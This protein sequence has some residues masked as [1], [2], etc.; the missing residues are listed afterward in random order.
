[1]GACLLPPHHPPPAAAL[2]PEPA[3]LSCHRCHCCHCRPAP[4]AC[5]G[6]A[7]DLS[8]TQRPKHQDVLKA[9]ADPAL[10]PISSPP[11]P[12]GLRNLRESSALCQEHPLLFLPQGSASTPVGI[13]PTP[14]FLRSR[15]LGA[16]WPQSSISGLWAWPADQCPLLLLAGLA[17][18]SR[19]CGSPHS[20]PASG[21]RSREGAAEVLSACSPRARTQ[22][23]H[24]SR[25]T[26]Q[27]MLWD[28]TEAGG[29]LFQPTPTLTRPMVWPF[30]AVTRLP[31][32]RPAQEQLGDR[33]RVW[34]D[35]RHP[36]P[37]SKAGAQCIFREETGTI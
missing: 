11:L 19:L 29:P 13:W 36:A 4:P 18:W 31:A 12:P 25:P 21:M 16:P 15:V 3:R 1:M 7:G 37:P 9:L 8:K 23:P 20:H 30:T 32:G 24:S 17:R 34:S 22:Q 26:K 14:P 10:R 5:G 33:P 28:R 27:C 6:G 35:L 2:V